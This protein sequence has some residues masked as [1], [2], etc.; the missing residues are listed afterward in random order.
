MPSRG[1]SAGSSG[2]GAGQDQTAAAP[3]TRSPRERSSAAAQPTRSHARRAPP[4]RART[5]RPTAGR[6]ARID[7]AAD[8]RSRGRSPTRSCRRVCTTSA[9]PKR[10]SARRCAGCD[11][12]PTRTRRRGNRASALRARSARTSSA[13][14]R[15]SPPSTP[16][17]RSVKPSTRTRGVAGEARARSASRERPLW[18]HRQTTCATSSSASASST[19]PSDVTHAPAASR[20][21]HDA[22]C[23]GQAERRA[24]VRGATSAPE[25]GPC[26]AVDAGIAVAAPGDAPHLRDR[27]GVCHE[28]HIHPAARPVVAARRDR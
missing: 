28:M 2:S 4:S 1:A 19:A 13:R 27:L 24:R 8:A 16:A 15:R 10:R 3:S 6:E 21:E 20:D 11:R 7:A 5:T 26:E 23:G 25:L 22:P 9:R 14:A 17:S 18:P 12:V